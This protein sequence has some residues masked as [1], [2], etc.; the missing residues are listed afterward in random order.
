MSK[1]LALWI[2]SHFFY[3]LYMK[4]FFSRL[5]LL[6]TVAGVMACEKDETRVVL[7][8]ATSPVLTA[9]RTDAGVLQAANSANDAV[10]YSWTPL[11][12]GIQ[13]EAKLASIVTYTLEIARTGRN[14]AP[15]AT[16]ALEAGRSTSRTYT[17]G[18]INGAMIRAGLT[19]NMSGQV[20]VRLK[21]VYASA[22]EPVYSSVV[23]LTG[24]PYSREL[25]A[26][27][28]F[29][30][31]PDLTVA[32]FIQITS[33]NPQLYEGYLYM[34]NATN[35]FRLSNTNT[36]SGTVYGGGSAPSGAPNSFAVNGGDITLA[37]PRQ[38]QLQV[39]LA[40]NSYTATPV[41][42]GIIGSA[43][44]QSWNASTPLTFDPQDKKWKGTLALVAGEIKFRANDA[45]TINLG[46]ESTGRMSYD[47]PN[48]LSPGV[49]SYDVVLDLNTP[50]D[51]RYTFTK[52]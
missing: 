39:N 48:I 19:P 37:G 50:N 22:Q 46:V 16:V 5:L 6:L 17:V 41:A 38:Y 42:W 26:F 12:F 31:T 51:Y 27:G 25:Y 52:K 20:D 1:E 21:A 2:L 45:W 15:A 43:T 34:P 9:D 32:P 7:T 40:S 3:D 49:G 30:G 23:T 33:S 29:Q 8:P 11:T 10:K 35:T 18:E 13:P 36:S 47:G 28:S 14:F 4:H 44:P 24:A